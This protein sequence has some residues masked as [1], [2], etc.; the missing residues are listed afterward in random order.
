MA[1]PP[2]S[3][4]KPLTAIAAIESNALDPDSSFFCQGFLTQPDRLRCMIYRL[5]KQGHNEV[6]LREALAESC[7]VYFF[8]AARRT[9][10]ESLR[11]W[12]ERLEFGRTTNCDLPFERAGNLPGQS[13][14]DKA[15][16]SSETLGLAIG[17]SSVTTTPIQIARLFAA[18]ANGGRLVTPHVVS[19][20]GLARATS[21]IDDRAQ[22][23]TRRRIAGLDPTT[24]SFVQ[25]G[26][27]A[28][29]NDPRGTAYRTV[30][31][32]DIEIAG[33]TG[34]AEVGNAKPDHAWFAGYVPATDPQYVVVVVLENGG[35]GSQVAGPIAKLLVSKLKQLG[36]L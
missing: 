16:A 24:L 35:S 21:D 36:L 11:T 15:A 1:I 6:R 33:K 22:S 5:N 4:F 28:C 14:Q 25:E 3:I 26:L 31:L 9:G 32:P 20:D 12:A 34:T 10:F 2:G 8:Q 23:L 30:R 13:S 29:V 18:I 7:N 27:A 19:Q 17:Q